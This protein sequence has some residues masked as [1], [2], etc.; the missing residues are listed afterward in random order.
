MEDTQR[1]LR[2]WLN[3]SKAGIEADSSPT[4]FTEFVPLLPLLEL[5]EFG[6]ARAVE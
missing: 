4:V 6:A 2:R 5:A 3:G 1:P